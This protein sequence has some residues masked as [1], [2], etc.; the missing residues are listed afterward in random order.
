ML[1]AGILAV[2]ASLNLSHAS[3]EKS[4]GY[5]VLFSMLVPV[6]KCSGPY[7]I[8]TVFGTVPLPFTQEC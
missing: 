3:P 7:I 1:A 4:T 6:N 8:I 5:C 2:K